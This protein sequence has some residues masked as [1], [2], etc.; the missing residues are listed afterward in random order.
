MISVLWKGRKRRL[1]ESWRGKE[2][3]GYRRITSLK[4]K[5]IRKGKRLD[6]K[7]KNLIK[8]AK[9]TFIYIYSP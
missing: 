9:K 1:L 3:K 4:I 7:P 8:S 5:K 2:Y 6:K